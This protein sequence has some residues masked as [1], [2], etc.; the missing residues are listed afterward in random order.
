VGF[1]HAGD[2]VTTTK[3]QGHHPLP[4]YY[5]PVEDRAVMLTYVLHGYGDYYICA[6]CGRIGHRIKSRR[7]GIRWWSKDAFFEDRFRN[8]ETWN[9]LYTPVYESRDSSKR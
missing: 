2:H 3:C 7:G 9:R 6:N 5:K 4:L 1:Y 8:A